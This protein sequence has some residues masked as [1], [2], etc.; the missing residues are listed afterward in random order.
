MG[1]EQILLDPTAE[2]TGTELD[3]TSNTAGYWLLAHAYPTPE[4]DS[5]WASSASTEGERRASTRPRNRTITVK[6]RCRETDDTE[7]ITALVQA[8]QAK[9]AKLDR[10]GG[11]YRRV[12]PSGDTI[13]FDVEE[14]S[15]QVPA[16]Q[17]WVSRKRADVDLTF[18]CKPYGRGDKVTLD[19]HSETTLPAL[20]FTE[21]AIAG[22]VQA[23]GELTITEEQDEDQAS[24]W[25]GIQSRHYSSD[26]TASL[27][28]QAEA[29][30]ALGTAATAVG[31]TGASGSGSNV[32]QAGSL[33]TLPDM[34]PV[35]SIGPSGPQT[36][37][38]AFRVLARVQLPATNAGEVS[39]G[40]AW[41][42]EYGAPSAH[43]TPV[44]VINL[45]GNPIEGSWVIVDLGLV[46]LPPVPVGDQGWFGMIEAGSTNSADK[47]N[48]DWVTLIPVT[49]G[50]G[51]S[52]NQLTATA[53]LA[54]SKMFAVRHDGV[55]GTVNSGYWY[56]DKYYTGD[57][58]LLP[59]A[60]PDGR[61]LRVV[62]KASRP[63]S[64]FAAP[65][66][67]IYWDNGIDDITAQL[68][69]TPRYL[70][71]PAP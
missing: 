35:V 45:A 23:L 39:V 24:V 12:L 31:P 10:E 1:G 11:T 57:Y 53:V 5:Q 66:R 17:A 2:G 52:S 27:F 4:H 29:C 20:V 54:A 71:V 40:C 28:Y 69:Y 26:S 65:G 55:Y 22:D 14:A 43:N 47:L 48:V 68:A 37:A 33:T 49:E 18:I 19:A 8:L 41:S 61:T 50:Y 16:D 56:R 63:P 58:L 59:P 42:P 46:N 30:E 44:R 34:T 3:I 36:H 38:G 13:T 7:E 62:V 32:V 9:I 51:L 60:G 25:W 21:T 15:I 67:G 6:V 70:V 64:G